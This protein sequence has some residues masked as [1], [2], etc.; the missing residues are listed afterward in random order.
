MNVLG[1]LVTLLIIGIVLWA[2]NS[3]IPMD[4]KIKKILNGVV[5]ILVIIWL[6]KALG[7]YHYLQSVFS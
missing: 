7:I 5:I 2:I 1:I 4:E 3:F 6:I